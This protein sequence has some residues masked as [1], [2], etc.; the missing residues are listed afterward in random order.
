[1]SARF[2][3]SAY[4]VALLN[5]QDALHQRAMSQSR[6]LGR[7][8]LITTEMVLTEVLNFFAERGSAPRR[9]AA[10]LVERLRQVGNVR[11]IPQTSAQFAD[12]LQLYRTR[13]DKEW[14]HTDCA[15]FRITARE[16]ITQALTYDRHFEQAG[17]K[18]LLRS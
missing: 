14:S 13:Q 9:A 7:D 8:R 1:M 2:A 10:D 4:W 15:S 3:D 17:F 12:A 5:P 6:S 16:R 11:I 18:A